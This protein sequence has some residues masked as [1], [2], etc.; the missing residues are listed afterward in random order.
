MFCWE[1]MWKRMRSVSKVIW[2]KL[3]RWIGKEILK[4]RWRFYISYGYL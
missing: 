2:K 4:K 3:T 1:S